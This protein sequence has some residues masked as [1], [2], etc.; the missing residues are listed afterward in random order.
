MTVHGIAKETSY[1]Y[2]IIGEQ[3]GQ[4]VKRPPSYH[5]FRGCR[6]KQKM[7]IRKV[8][9]HI[10]AQMVLRPTVKEQGMMK[11]ELNSL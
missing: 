6:E 5:E 10:F 7:D 2:S 4:A 11:A 3:H 8:S 9:L 1:T